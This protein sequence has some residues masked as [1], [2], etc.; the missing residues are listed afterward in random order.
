MRI[1]SSSSFILAATL[2]VSSSTPSL[3]APAGETSEGGMSSSTSNHFIASRNGPIPRD[4][5]DQDGV[6]DV[7]H[8]VAAKDPGQENLR[9]MLDVTGILNGANGV[10]AP[11]PDGA[12]VEPV[13]GVIGGAVPVLIKGAMRRDKMGTDSSPSSAPT[14]AIDSPVTPGDSAGTPNNTPNIAAIPAD[15]VGPAGGIPIAVPMAPIPAPIA[16][17]LHQ[18]NPA[19]AVLPLNVEAVP[20]AGAAPAGPP[21]AVG[22]PPRPQT[23]S[24]A[25]PS[26]PSDASPGGVPPPLPQAAAGALPAPNPPTSA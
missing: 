13:A 21:A 19:G 14:Q 26:P 17:K 11:V 1:S 24:T 5:V 12:P 4:T 25:P 7:L 10:A 22:G 8:K 16:D 18:P 6:A 20:V 23:G 15:V 2:A 3:A 9:N